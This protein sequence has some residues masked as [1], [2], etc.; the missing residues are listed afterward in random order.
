MMARACWWWWWRRCCV[1]QGLEEKEK[2]EKRAD[3]REGW[4][5]RGGAV[6]CHLQCLGHR[7]P[8]WN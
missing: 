6:V 8:A 5:G 4:P 3:V 7:R 2:Q 1:F